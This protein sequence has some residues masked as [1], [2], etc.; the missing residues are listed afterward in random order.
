MGM[1][2]TENEACPSSDFESGNPHGS[3]WGDGHYACQVCKHF[4]SDFVGEEG[5]HKRE[6]L[7]TTPRHQIQIIIFK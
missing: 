4:R 2:R 3:C 7:L 5:F 6:A 1:R